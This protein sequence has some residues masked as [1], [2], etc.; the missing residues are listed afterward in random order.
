MAN[1]LFASL[2]PGAI[3][4]AEPMFGPVQAIVAAAA[5]D[6][7]GAVRIT[8]ISSFFIRKPRCET[9]PASCRRKAVRNFHRPGFGKTKLFVNDEA[10]AAAQDYFGRPET[11]PVA[12]SGSQAAL[13]RL[14]A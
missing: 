14:A 8:A 2:G 1:S 9:K 7:A 13:P 11:L 5:G 3:I 12:I 10:C 4:A 6:K